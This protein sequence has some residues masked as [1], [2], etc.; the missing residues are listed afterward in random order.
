MWSRYR[1]QQFNDGRDRTKPEPDPWLADAR[2][3]FIRITTDYA[4]VTSVDGTFRLADKA[5]AELTR[6][7]NLPNLQIGM[8][9]PEIVGED[10]D[11]KP[12][13][14]SD[15]RGKVV[16]VCFWATWCGPCMAMVPD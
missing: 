5:R 16:V 9:A 8:R 15:H 7:A 13:K 6:I 11:G 4:D 2:R 3:A 12:L 1:A 10:L 14:L